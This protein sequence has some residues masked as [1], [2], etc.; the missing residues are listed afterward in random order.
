MKNFEH[1]IIGGLL[2]QYQ[3]M[4]IPPS[5]T[6]LL[7]LQLSQREHPYVLIVLGKQVDL[8]KNFSR[9]K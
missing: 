8:N 9:D 6:L 4:Q 3:T 7:L 1:R 2:S 5:R